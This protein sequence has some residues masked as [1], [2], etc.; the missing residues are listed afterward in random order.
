[1]K[2]SKYESDFYALAHEQATLLRARKFDDIDLKNIAEEIETLARNE[3]RELVNRLKQLLTHL[4]KWQFQLNFQSRS[5]LL[6]IEEQREEL[7]QHLA[8][9]LSLKS[10]LEEALINSYEIAIILAKKQTGLETF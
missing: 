1:M 2:S 6:T 5:W 10:R 3:Y 8:A 9:N 4:L 7:V